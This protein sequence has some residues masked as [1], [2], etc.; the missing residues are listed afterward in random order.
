MIVRSPIESGKSDVLKANANGF[1]HGLEIQVGHDW[2]PSWS[3]RFRISLMDS[4]VEQLLDNNATGSITVDGRNY[5]P[6][7]RATTRLMPPQFHFVTRYAPP[8]SNWW[9]DFSILAV[10]RADDLS[11]K[12]ETDSSRIPSNGTPGYALFGISGGRKWGEDSSVFLAVENLS[13]VDY[14]VH[15]SGLNGGGRN[16]IFSFSRSF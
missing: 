5:N 11:L 7:D 1:I 3:S 8:Q 14:R 13:D 9:G 4:E 6:V 16:F 12:D 10:G 15:G 2:S